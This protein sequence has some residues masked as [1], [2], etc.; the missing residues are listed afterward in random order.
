MKQLLSKSIFDFHFW[1]AF[2]FYVYVQ[3]ATRL[4]G[5]AKW[6]SPQRTSHHGEFAPGCLKLSQR[7]GQYLTR[8]SG[9]T[10]IID[11][12]MR[13]DINKPWGIQ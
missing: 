4:L 7:G 5:L 11:D 3:S 6:L 9:D 2:V 12:H 13:S 8:I 10:S 1:Y